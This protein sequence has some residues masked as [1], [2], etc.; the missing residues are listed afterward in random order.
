MPVSDKMELDSEKEKIALDHAWAWFSLH[1][2]QRLQSVNFFLVATAFLS[3]AFVT[4]AKEKMY[5]LAGGIAVL[6]VLISYVLYRMER[7]V[8][9]LIHA[10]E[11][12][13]APL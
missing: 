11:H 1:A 4:A 6:A 3:A 8:R 12:A 9:S 2:T 5:A 7:R 10:A 13:I